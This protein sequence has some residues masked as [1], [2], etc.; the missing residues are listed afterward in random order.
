[1]EVLVRRS[2]N[3]LI[4]LWVT[5]VLPPILIL[6]YLIFIQFDFS[7]VDFAYWVVGTILL[8]ASILYA[9]LFGKTMFLPNIVIK[10]D[11][12]KLHIYTGLK[13]EEAVELFDIVD[14]IAIKNGR[15]AF[16]RLNTVNRLYGKLIIKTMQRK[17]ELYPVSKVDEAKK[18]LEKYIQSHSVK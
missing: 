9:V 4:Q 7:Q 3:G 1:M 15:M 8:T 17:Y 14:I 11:E 5:I 16:L 12:K 10:G 18:R 13:H 6:A 2:L